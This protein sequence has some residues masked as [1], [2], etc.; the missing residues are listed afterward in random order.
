MSWVHILSEYYNSTHNILLTKEECITFEAMNFL[1][2]GE[3]DYPNVKEALYGRRLLFIRGDGGSTLVLK[4]S[5]INNGEN[6]YI[7]TYGVTA[8]LL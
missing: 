4:F 1:K 7:F 5:A 8:V 2:H 6:A 3:F